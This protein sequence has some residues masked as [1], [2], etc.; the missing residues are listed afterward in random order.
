MI[1]TILRLDWAQMRVPPDLL[2]NQM[3]GLVTA[4]TELPDGRLIMMMDV[5]K[6]LAESNQNSDDIQMR[7][8]E[9][10]RIEGI[11]VFFF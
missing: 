10:H 8:V 2:S 4:V 11:T 7:A 6:I 3:N 5:E 9:Q 1:D